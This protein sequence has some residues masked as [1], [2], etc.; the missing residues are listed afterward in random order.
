MTQNKPVQYNDSIPPFFE[1]SPV[2]SLEP[3]PENSEPEYIVENSLRWVRPYYFTY[4]AFAKQRWLNKK[5][6]DVMIENFH[7]PEPETYWTHRIVHGFVTINDSSKEPDY[8]V[9]DR[10]KGGADVLKHRVI[11][12]E[13]PVTADLPVILG[14]TEDFLAINKPCTIP[15]H[16]GGRFNYNALDSIVPRF[17]SLPDLKLVHRLDRVTSGVLIYGK[18]K[19]AAN[20]FRTWLINNSLTKC[21][22]AKVDG[23][24]TEIQKRCGAFISAPGPSPFFQ[25]RG[26]EEEEEGSQSAETVFFSLWSSSTSSI[27]AAFPI[28]GRCHQ[29]RVHLAHLGFPISNDL[30]YNEELKLRSE[31]SADDNRF[32]KIHLHAVRYKGPK[33]DFRSELPSWVRTDEGVDISEVVERNLEDAWKTMVK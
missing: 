3:L 29:I 2:H 9:S 11:R 16:K 6:I 1:N 5:L 15:C 19:D 12:Y 23:E 28:T 27:V 14:E 21:Y 31:F 30:L 26:L 22:I 24:F 20:L 32:N 10:K 7:H 17:L 25:R 18:T 8:V 4:T 13:E 33:F